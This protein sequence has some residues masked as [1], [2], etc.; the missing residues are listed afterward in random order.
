MGRSIPTG[1]VTP[2]WQGNRAELTALP[3]PA[4]T[5]RLDTAAWAAW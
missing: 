2:S 3:A 4:R 1:A 5:L